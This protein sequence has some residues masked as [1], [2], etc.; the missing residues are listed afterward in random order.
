MTHEVNHSLYTR[1]LPYGTPLNSL[2][3]GLLIVSFNRLIVRV[4]EI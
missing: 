1:L 2:L 3:I 4:S